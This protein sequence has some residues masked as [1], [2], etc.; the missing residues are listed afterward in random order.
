MVV[1]KI[2]KCKCT[3]IVKFL[4]AVGVNKESFVN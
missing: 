3:G 2:E 1:Q 4:R